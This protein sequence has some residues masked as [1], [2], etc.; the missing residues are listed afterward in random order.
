M[1]YLGVFRRVIPSFGGIDFSPV[2]AIL[3]LSILQPIVVRLILML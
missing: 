1:P 3:A 2:V